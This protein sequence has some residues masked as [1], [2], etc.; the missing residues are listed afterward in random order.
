MFTERRIYPCPNLDQFWDSVVF[1]IGE[2]KPARRVANETRSGMLRDAVLTV[3]LL[4]APLHCSLP[5]RRLAAPLDPTCMSRPA[6]QPAA[7]PTTQLSH[8]QVHD[9]VPLRWPTLRG[10]KGTALVSP[11]RESHGQ[12]FA[13]G[14]AAEPA[15]NAQSRRRRRRRY[16]HRRHMHRRPHPAGPSVLQRR[17]R[18]M[19]CA[20]L[21]G[22]Q[23]A[24]NASPRRRRRP[25]GPAASVQSSA[26]TSLSRSSALGTGAVAAS[27]AGTWVPSPRTA[28]HVAI[29]VPTRRRDGTERVNALGVAAAAARCAAQITSPDRGSGKRRSQYQRPPDVQ[30][31]AQASLTPA[32]RGSALGAAAVPARSVRCPRRRPRHHHR[33]HRR[34][35]PY[36]PRPCYRLHPRR[37]CRP[38]RRRCPRHS[39]RTPGAP[40]GPRVA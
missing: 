8:P 39:Q 35:P 17:N 34:R 6:P 23:A 25:L 10:A 15:W 27:N 1:A 28:A 24:Q 20:T 33:R 12:T 9:C 5:T 21:V 13:A 22:V 11:Q 18:G 7:R 40:R 30:T 26:R 37:R 38:R 31:T 3:L 2:E 16:R 36:L 32:L 29:T 14:P 19:S 4:E